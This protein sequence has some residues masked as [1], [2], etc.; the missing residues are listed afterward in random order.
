MDDETNQEAFR[1]PP[2][3]MGCRGHRGYKGRLGPA[4]KIGPPGPHGPPGPKGPPGSIG[5]RGPKGLAGSLGPRGPPGPCGVPG[6]KGHK[7]PSDGPEGCPGPIGDKGPRGDKGLDGPKGTQGDAG[8]QGPE[9]IVGPPGSIGVCGEDGEFG[10]DGPQGCD[11]DPGA[12]G[13]GGEPGNIPNNFTFYILKL[14]KIPP[15]L[16]VGEQKPII[17]LGSFGV[18]YDSLSESSA[19]N[20]EFHIARPAMNELEVIF[21]TDQL[22]DQVYGLIPF[23]TQPNHKTSR[24]DPTDIGAVSGETVFKNITAPLWTQGLIILIKFKWNIS[25]Q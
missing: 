18:Y 16:A 15:I 17:E 21:T 4:G 20:V 11:G 22:I 2:G 7:G 25:V 3:P 9:G 12:P 10:E 24:S 19:V 23:Y 14:N 1:G 8:I 6:P 5:K 13:I